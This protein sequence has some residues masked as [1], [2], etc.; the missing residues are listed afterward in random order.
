MDPTVVVVDAEIVGRDPSPDVRAS[1][2]RIPKP[3]V[4]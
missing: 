1:L 4:Q 2:R 3:D